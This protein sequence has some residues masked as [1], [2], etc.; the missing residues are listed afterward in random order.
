MQYMMGS[1]WI[2]KQ[3]YVGCHALEYHNIVNN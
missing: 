2:V 1:I 3:D